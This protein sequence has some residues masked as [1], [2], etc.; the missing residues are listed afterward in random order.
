[1]GS[2]PTEEQQTRLLWLRQ[3]FEKCREQTICLYAAFVD[4]TKAVDIDNHDGLWKKLCALDKQ[5]NKQRFQYVLVRNQP[6]N[7][8]SSHYAV[9]LSMYGT[10]YGI[11][12]DL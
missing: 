1:M 2:G 6:V 8:D 4:L 3:I 5:I 10:W 11:L 7:I 9:F 12:S